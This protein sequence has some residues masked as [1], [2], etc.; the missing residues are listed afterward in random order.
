MKIALV[1]GPVFFYDLSDE[2]IEVIDE[3][4]QFTKE[5]ARL[6]YGYEISTRLEFNIRNNFSLFSGVVLSDR[7]SRR[8]KIRDDIVMPVGIEF[9]FF[10]RF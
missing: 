10:K 8:H 7:G 2:I 5:D 6:T 9:G 3:G 4:L 1:A